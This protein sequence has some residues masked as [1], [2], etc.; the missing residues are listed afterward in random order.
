LFFVEVEW[1]IEQGEIIGKEVFKEGERLDK[2]SNVPKQ[3]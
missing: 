2:Y 1:D 3:V